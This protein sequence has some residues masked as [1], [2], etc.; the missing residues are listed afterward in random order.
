MENASNRQSD[1]PTS[2]QPRM[3]IHCYFAHP[4][5]LLYSNLDC[6][7]ILLKKPWLSPCSQLMNSTTKPQLEKRLVGSHLIGKPLVKNRSEIKTG[8]S[9]LNWSEIHQQKWSRNRSVCAHLLSF[10]SFGEINKRRAQTSD[11]QER[12][13][14][15]AGK[16]LAAVKKLSC[17]L[18]KPSGKLLYCGRF[19]FQP[20]GKE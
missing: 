4:K 13:T 7:F 16:P 3:E 19:L 11:K 15:T 1:D 2:S 6:G 9:P 10:L 8:R 14:I 18:Y 17:R 12:I 5:I 20:S